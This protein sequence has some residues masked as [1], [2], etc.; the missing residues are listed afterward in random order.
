M[1]QFFFNI[2][3]NCAIFFN[4]SPSA[5]SEEKFFVLPKDECCDCERLNVYKEVLT[6]TEALKAKLDR[7]LKVCCF[8]NHVYPQHPYISIGILH[9]VLVIFPKVLTRKI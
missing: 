2:F 7:C 9:T 6:S 1:M 8:L 5:D 4:I 3:I